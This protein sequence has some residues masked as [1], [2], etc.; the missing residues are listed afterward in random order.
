MHA[1]TYIYP[2]VVFL[3]VLALLIIFC[4][5]VFLTL[6]GL[7]IYSLIRLFNLLQE[8]GRTGIPLWFTEMKNAIFNTLPIQEYSLKAEEIE[9]SDAEDAV[10]EIEVDIKREEDNEYSDALLSGSSTQEES[11]PSDEDVK[12]QS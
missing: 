2:L 9:L 12:A 3:L 10:A 11:F 5:S 7:S 6:T 8:H 1:Q 4:S